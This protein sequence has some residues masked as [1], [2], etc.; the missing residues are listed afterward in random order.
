MKNDKLK[1]AIIDANI[2]RVSEGLRVV[3]DWARFFLRD[4]DITD[5]IRVLRHGLWQTVCGVYPKIIKGRD[6]GEDILRETSEG[7]R[8]KLNDIPAAS[9]NRV[10]EGLRVLEE[11][12][13][14]I[15][16]DSSKIFKDMRFKIYDIE[17][18]FYEKRT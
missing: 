12:G 4:K 10:K 16:S 17:K 1:K 14:L 2:N 18:E 15:S 5:S 8:K 13:K 3:E 7:I 9:F 6:T 11:M